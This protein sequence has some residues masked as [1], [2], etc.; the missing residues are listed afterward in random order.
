MPSYSQLTSLPPLVT[1]LLFVCWASITAFWIYWANRKQAHKFIEPHAKQ[2]L[3]YWLPFFSA[4]ALLAPC[5]RLEHSPLGH[6]LF[7]P[8]AMSYSAGLLLATVGVALGIWARVSLADNW[9]GNVTLKQSHRLITTGPYRW[10][11]HPI[12]SAFLLL[13]I[14]TA[15]CTAQLRGALAVALVFISFYYKWRSEEQLM[16]REFGEQYL[17]YRKQSGAI[18]PRW[19]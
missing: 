3:I 8:S 10:L 18:I 4:A 2:I 7:T 19:L 16:L 1:A 14:G 17:R 11:R 5:P 15:I 13:I 9:S 6:W 12:Y